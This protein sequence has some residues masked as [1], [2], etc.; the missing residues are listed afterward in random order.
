LAVVVLAASCLAAACTEV[1]GTPWPAGRDDIEVRGREV[2]L[3]LGC[4]D[5]HD[6]RADAPSRALDLRLHGGPRSAGWYAMQLF[7]PVL[8][9]GGSTK[10]PAPLLFE[11]GAEDWDPWEDAHLPAPGLT[12]GGRAL[13]AY[14]LLLEE[15]PE[16]EAAP[17]SGLPPLGE[18]DMGVDDLYRALCASCHGTEG[19]GDGPGAAFLRAFGETEPRAFRPGRFR[20]RSRMDLPT[21]ED[22]LATITHGLP[23]TAMPDFAHLS[24]SD[25][26]DLVQHVKAFAVRREADGS[27]NDPFAEAD[28]SSEEV[29]DFIA[30]FGSGV[31]DGPTRTRGDE[32]L[33]SLGC[34]ACHGDDMRGRWAAD[35]GLDW[36]DEIERPIPWATDLVAGRFKGGDDGPALMR[37]LLMGQGGAPMPSYAE[38]LPELADARAVVHAMLAR[39]AAHRAAQA[40]H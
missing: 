34:G 12:E 33:V 40:T 16:R 24:E 21:D 30:A 38:A 11:D 5:C 32:L 22:L 29:F 2:F 19:N 6:G 17:G 31:A 4:Q 25:R 13:V 26:L 18:H 28:E 10:P 36:R 8:A 37:T 27:R 35:L 23:G 9:R 3:E 20:V 39:R 14:L 1:P 15:L 7:S